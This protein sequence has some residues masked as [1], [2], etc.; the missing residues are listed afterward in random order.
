MK[1]KTTDQNKKKDHYDI[2]FLKISILSFDK[3]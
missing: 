1:A 2:F 3:F